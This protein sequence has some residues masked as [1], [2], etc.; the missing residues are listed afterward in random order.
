MSRC[1]YR[2][3]LHGGAKIVFNR[4]IRGECNTRVFEAMAAGAL[5]LQERENREVSDLLE[6]GRE[7]VAYGP[8]DFEGVIEHYLTH[9]EERRAITEAAWARRDEFTYAACWRR[10]LATL[11]PEWVEIREQAAR[12]ASARVIASVSAGVWAA[13]S[14]GG[15]HELRA[16]LGGLH[17]ESGGLRKA[18]THPTEEAVAANAAGVLAGTANDAAHCF[19]AALRLDP[20]FAVA[21]LNRAE[22]LTQAGRGAEAVTQALQALALFERGALMSDV[23]LDAPHFPPGFD[24]LGVEWERAGWHNA[25]SRDGER[26][27]KRNLL[28][29]WLHSLLADLTG[30]LDHYRAAARARPDLRPFKAALGCALGRANQMAEALPILG[31]AVAANPFDR[32]AARALCQVLKNLG[33]WP[34][35]AAFVREQMNLHRAAPG[36]VPLEN[37]IREEP[38]PSGL[39]RTSIIILACNEVEFTRLCLESV[40]KHTQGDYELILVDNAS[41][42]DTPRLF[43]EMRTRPGPARVEVIRNETNLGFAKGVNQGLAA[44][45]GEFLV[46]LNNDTV[47]TP[48]WLGGLIGWSLCDWPRVG[49]V[50]PMTNY[51]AHP[52]LIEPGY[53]ELAGL[54]EF[55]RERRRQFKGKALDVPRLTGF[56]LLVRRAVLERIGG[57]LDE[58]FGLGFFEDD[59]LSF[60]ARQAGFKLWAAQDVYIHHFGSRTFTGLG[61]DTERQLLDN[62]QIFRAKWGD[63]AAANYRMR[64]GQSRTDCQSVLRQGV[65]GRVESSRPAGGD[66]VAPA[67]LED[68]TRPTRPG[69]ELA[70]AARPKV[71]LCMIVK[72][73]EKNLADCLGPIR[74]V[75]DEVIVVDTGSTDR[76]WELAEALGARV[77]DFP[78]QDSFSAA[79]NVAIEHARGEWIFWLDADDRITPEN[80][81]KLKRLFAILDGSNRAFVM[82]CVCVAATPGETETVVDHLRLFRNDPR[83]RWTYRVHEQILPAIRA[84]RAEVLWTDVT[85]LHTG[86]TDEVLR[87]KKLDRDLRLLNMEYQEQ[88]D[89]PFTLFNMGSVLRE[90]GRTAEAL[91]MLERSLARSHPNDSIV[92]K[93]YSMIAQ[94]R[95]QL[96]SLDAALATCGQGRALY[97]NDAELLLVESMML[98]E[99]GDPRGAEQRLQELIAGRDDDHFASVA[100][101]LRGYKARHTLAVLYLAEGRHSE[102]EAQWRAA[103]LDNPFYLPAQA[104]IG[105]A[106]LRGGKWDALD[107]HLETLGKLGPQAEEEAEL[108]RGRALIERQEFA[109]AR[110]AIARAT[111]R[112]R[113]SVNLRVLYAHALLREGTDIPAAEEALL[114]VLALAPDHVETKN[115]LAAL[116]AWRQPAPVEAAPRILVLCTDNPAPSGGVRRLYRHVDVLRAQ[117]VPA[118]VVHEKPGFRCQ[119]FANDTPVLALGQ[120]AIRSSDFLVIP[121]I[122]AANLAQLAPGVRKIIYSQNAYYTFR[123]WPREGLNGQCPYRHP[124]VLATLAVS[125]DNLAYL[126]YAFPNL[127]AHRV[128]YGIDPVF[129]PSWPKRRALAFMPRKNAD[130]ALQVLNILHARGALTGWEL[131]SIDGQPEEQ[132]AERL[133]SSALFLSFGYPEGCPLPPLEAMASGCVVA[134]YH[135]RG[136]REYFDPAFSHPIEAG[137]IIGFARTVEDLLRQEQAEPGLLESQGRLAS[138]FVRANYSPEREARDIVDIWR[139]ILGPLQQV[140]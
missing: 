34:E 108:L 12:R 113:R 1:E 132:V 44:A 116:Q 126:R 59:D 123:G 29:C 129:A 102:A 136:G 133:R 19:A 107:K 88:P 49:L 130:D 128:H 47:V 11:E 62:F 85:I 114:A 64:A 10:A 13:V 134:G 23:S 37:W 118:W 104:G 138:E 90:L 97:P 84:T 121:E 26:D 73:E 35:R 41:T 96:G 27:E 110:A 43:E 101:G 36:K 115:S 81:A 100:V 103:L 18:S 6:A 3:L 57:K 55:A 28:S 74:D 94:C 122:F 95:Q 83:L 7:Y 63:E 40:L 14:G 58:R 120:A 65:V 8:D 52:Q 17:T 25:G 2:E 137:D 135:G 22:A 31:E 117:G 66:R 111:E 42:D 139:N 20:G 105:E 67:G 140:V 99:K 91:A 68:S 109:A 56:C 124:D 9:D 46:L 53:R 38:P 77:F 87:R 119:W 72:N 60:H 61:I 24:L 16:A 78:W 86:Y 51:T 75:V 92:R 54:D 39:E 5:L 45:R 106:L 112:F 82:K 131:V 71:S 4:S 98:R 93:L 89:D 48:D 30:D 76:T 127:P 69:F 32:Q 79:R 15:V 125:D 70:S 21:G 80:I 33:D 50:G